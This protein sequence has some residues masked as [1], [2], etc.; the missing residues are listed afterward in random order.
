VSFFC[1]KCGQYKQ[2][3]FQSISS[4]TYCTSCEEKIAKAGVMTEDKIIKIAS[5]ATYKARYIKNRMDDYL[6]KRRL[7]YELLSFEIDG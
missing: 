6:E 7:K 1:N 3:E 2:K 4:V 5:K